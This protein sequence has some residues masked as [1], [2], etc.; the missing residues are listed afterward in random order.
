MSDEITGKG[1]A[2]PEPELR[3]LRDLRLKL[4]HLHKSLGQGAREL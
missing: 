1:H 3:Q 4:L 2:F